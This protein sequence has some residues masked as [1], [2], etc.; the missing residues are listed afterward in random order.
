MGEKSISK[1]RI[2]P[3]LTHFQTVTHASKNVF[4]IVIQHI[5]STIFSSSFSRNYVLKTLKID[6]CG[7]VQAGFPPETKC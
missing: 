3:T 4:F 5:K 7:H 2:S 1:N 6:S